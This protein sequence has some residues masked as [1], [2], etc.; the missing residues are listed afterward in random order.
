MGEMVVV[1]LDQIW[2][3]FLQIWD[4]ERCCGI[5][6]NVDL[7]GSLEGWDCVGGSGLGGVGR[8]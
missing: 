3:K 2:V 4:L 1:I 6:T 8:W 7:V 5:I